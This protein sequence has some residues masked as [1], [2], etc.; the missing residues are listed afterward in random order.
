MMT[1]YEMI[2][3]YG[4]GRGEGKMWESVAVISDAV[5]KYMSSEAKH[6]LMREIYCVMSGGHYNEEFAKEDVAKMHY[7]DMAGVTHHAPFFTYEKVSEIY[8]KIRER[9]PSYNMW[10]FY[11]TLNMIESDYA[12]L[13]KNWFP[14]ASEE[15]KEKYYIELALNWLNDPDNPY[16][17][18]KIWKY[19]NS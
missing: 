3:T 17:M 12:C 5:E 1:M 11:V 19:L 14:D 2:E 4:K 7:K 15:Q 13:M 18:E 9:I 10:D 6:H 8:E 16:G